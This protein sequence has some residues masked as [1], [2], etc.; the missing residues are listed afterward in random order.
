MHLFLVS[1]PWCGRYLRGLSPAGDTVTVEMVS[2]HAGDDPELMINGDPA[3]EE[4]FAW[5]PT[6]PGTTPEAAM[7]GM[8]GSGDGVHVLTGPI[9]VEGA[10]PGD[11]LAVEVLGLR[12]RVNPEGRSFGVNAAAWW[13]F[14]YGTNGNKDVLGDML[15]MTTGDATREVTN[16][17]E[18][19]L[20]PT[21]PTNVLHVEPHYQAIYG[22]NEAVVTPCLTDP[23]R[24]SFSPGV[25]V[26]CVNG[27]QT[28]TGYYFP[29]LLT[30]TSRVDKNY[31]IQ[32]KF[33][34]AS[35]L[36][37]GCMGLAPPAPEFVDS[38]KRLPGRSLACLPACMPAGACPVWHMPMVL[39]ECPC[40][41]D[42][43][44]LSR[45]R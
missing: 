33:K 26:P 29:G 20:D 1:N 44:T 24:T 42:P 11:I 2:H 14:H 37:I 30:N 25:E 9:Y 16:V 18:A 12:P 17:Y 10:Q 23:A 4:I 35:K 27:T 45:L 8:T 3:L 28:W 21:D 5:A 39:S 41:N 6:G 43:T 31:G 38:S 22:Q 34:I 36:H 19:I 40:A 13:G 15:G 7:R 32:G